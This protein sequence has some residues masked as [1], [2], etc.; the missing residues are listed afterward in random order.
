VERGLCEHAQP[1]ICADS[2][3]GGLLTRLFRGALGNEGVCSVGFWEG[4]LA[5]FI[6]RWYWE[7]EEKAPRPMEFGLGSLHVASS[8]GPKFM[9]LCSVLCL[10]YYIGSLCSGGFA[11]ATGGMCWFGVWW[12]H[13][14]DV[15][16]TGCTQ[17]GPADRHVS[18]YTSLV[19]GGLR[20]S[21][22]RS[23]HCLRSG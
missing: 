21:G 7:W 22:R 14:T 19:G 23:E 3:D 17:L 20:F 1:Y 10:I 11:D 12:G 5:L 16:W 18:F 2:D 9:Y 6:G 15:P 13:D 4:T 8:N